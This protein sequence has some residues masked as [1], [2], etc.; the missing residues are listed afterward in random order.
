MAKN[1]TIVRRLSVEVEFHQ[2][3]MMHVVHNSEYFRWF[4]KGRLRMLADIFPVS[5]CVENRIATPVVMNHA[6]YLWPA[7]FEEVLVVTT[8]HSIMDRW[9]GRFVFE[10]SISNEKTKNELCFGQSALTVMDLSSGRLVKNISDEIC[11]R[12]QAL[13]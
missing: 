13:A 11:E 4:E 6:E 5:W 8:R 2:V 10:H 12:Y 7:R 3:D 9:D 1:R